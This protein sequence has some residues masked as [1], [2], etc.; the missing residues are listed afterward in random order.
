MKLVL[1]GKIKFAEIKRVFEDFE[2]DWD[3]VK[4]FFSKSFQRIHNVYLTFK[5]QEEAKKC[6]DQREE[7]IKQFTD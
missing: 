6:Y 7:M 5:S 3:H 1:G 4:Y 2:I